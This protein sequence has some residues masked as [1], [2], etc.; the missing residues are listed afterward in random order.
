MGGLHHVFPDFFLGVFQ[1]E[2]CQ[3]RTRGHAVSG[4]AVV[5]FK[6]IVDDFRFFLVEGAEFCPLLEEDAD[7][8]FGDR[9]LTA[10][11]HA[12]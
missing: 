7:F 12:D 5:E 9:L 2:P 1:V 6:D 4:G 11:F 8:F 10:H 3:L